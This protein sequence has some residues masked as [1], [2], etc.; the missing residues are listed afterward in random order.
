M[1]FDIPAQTEDYRV[2]IADFVEREI[3][4]LEA[5]KMSY[6]AH[7]NIALPLLEVLRAKARMAGLW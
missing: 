4:P 5:D 1:N 3:L 6:D 2:R 7:G